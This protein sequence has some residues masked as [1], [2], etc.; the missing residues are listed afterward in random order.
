MTMLEKK[1]PIHLEP[2]SALTTEDNVFRILPAAIDLAPR[3][4][5]QELDFKIYGSYT[6]RR[7]HGFKPFKPKNEDAT[8]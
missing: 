7:R 1:E 6:P 4:G 5:F 2:V 3:T 8:A